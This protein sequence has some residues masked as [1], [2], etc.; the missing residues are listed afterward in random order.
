MSALDKAVET[1]NPIISDLGLELVDVVFGGGRLVVTID[2]PDGLGTDLLTRCTRMISNELD[3]TDP[4]PNQYTLE[5]TSPGVER[6][7][8][9]PAQFE[10]SVGEKV[11]IKLTAPAFEVHQLRRV[12]GVLSSVNEDSI[13]VQLE[14]QISDEPSVEQDQIS[15]RFEEISK[16]KTTFEW[17]P[18]PKPGKGPKKK[19]KG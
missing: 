2:H 10:R 17:G 19:P 18:K 1:I 4:F 12:K 16:A 9:T 8:R 11:A 3:V 13:T 6:K 14:S 7:L 15:L 5:V